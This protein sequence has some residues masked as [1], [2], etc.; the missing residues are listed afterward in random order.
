MGTLNSSL[1]WQIHAF[2]GGLAVALGAFAAHG[3]KKH[4]SDVKLL[5]TWET[6]VKYQFAHSL[7]GLIS[8][9]ARNR[10][11]K[12]GASSIANLRQATEAPIYASNFAMIGNLLFSGSLYLLVL[13]GQKKLGMITPIGGVL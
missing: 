5:E 7:M 2:S 1:S 9:I 11:L 13:S 4:I 6:A 3:L 10:N 12:H 8:I